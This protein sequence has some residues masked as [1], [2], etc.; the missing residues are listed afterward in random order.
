MHH[1]WGPPKQAKGKVCVG[2]WTYIRAKQSLHS[3][4]YVTPSVPQTGSYIREQSG[5]SVMC[6]QMGI[7]EKT[8]FS[9][10]TGTSERQKSKVRL[11]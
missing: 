8:C 11:Y 7:L 3:L 5:D 9:A 2:G 10:D 4:S 1:R 6:S